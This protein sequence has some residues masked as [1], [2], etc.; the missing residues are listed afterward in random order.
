MKTRQIIHNSIRTPDGTILISRYG[1]HYAT[2]VDANGD[3]YTTDG[4]LDYLHRSVNVVPAEDLTLYTDTPFKTIREYLERGGRGVSG[5]EPLKYVVLKN[6][7]GN[8]L[9]AIIDYEELNRP[10]NPYLK[11]YKLEQKWRKNSTIK[12]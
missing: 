6:I 2:H 3:T 5:D 4:G 11:F 7:D 1:H 9:Q 12:K 8:W 10:K